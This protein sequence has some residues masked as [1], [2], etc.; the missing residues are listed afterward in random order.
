MNIRAAGRT[1]RN[2]GFPT[3]ALL[4]SRTKLRSFRRP[5]TGAAHWRKETYPPA[6]FCTRS[7]TSKRGTL[8]RKRWKQSWK[9]S[10]GIWSFMRKA[11]ITVPKP[12]IRSR[13][14][15]CI[16]GGQNQVN[17]K[18][19]KKQMGTISKNIP[20]LAW[21]LRLDKGLCFPYIYS[22]QIPILNTKG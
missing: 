5:I 12:E 10:C 14:I 7:G 15:D 8:T 19:G 4:I 17:R 2:E 13:R 20:T 1:W 21:G 16:S 11:R 9:C 22:H 6:R 3:I 18:D